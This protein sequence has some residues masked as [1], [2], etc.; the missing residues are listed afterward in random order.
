MDRFLRRTGAASPENDPEPW[1]PGKQVYGLRAMDGLVYM[2]AVITPN[3]S[4]SQRGFIVLICIV[5]FF[6]CAAAAVF[7]AMGATLVPFFLGLDVLAVIAAFLASYAAARRVERVRVTSREVRV[8]RETPSHSEVVWESPTAF[9]RVA[10]EL[11]EDEVVQA[12]R[13]AVSGRH[14][15]VAMALSPPERADFARHL[16]WAIYEARRG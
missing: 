3:R 5:T 12:V 11:D 8:V 13:L 7:L 6:N 10:L 4:L 14:A 2:D 16:E 1:R 9:T 15:S